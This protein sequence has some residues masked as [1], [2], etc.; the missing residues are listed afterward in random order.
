[1]S[2]SLDSRA[3]RR[4]DWLH[5]AVGLLGVAAF[6]LVLR[7]VQ[8]AN[9]TTVSLGLL[10][11]VLIV[12]SWSRLWVAVVTAVA[13]MLAFN[14]FFLPPVGTLTISDPHNWVALLAFLVAAVIASQLS[15]A[16][17]A[18]A[19]DA[20]DRRNELARLFD[21]S[22]D[23]LLT[24]DGASTLDALARHI[25]RRFDLERV[26]LCLPASPGW[27]IHQGGERDD[28]VVDEEELGVA[29][30][31]AG[32]TIEFDARQRT[33]GG[34]ARAQ[35]TSGREVTLVPVRFGTRAIGLLAAPAGAFDPGALDAVAGFAAIA[36]ERAQLLN[37]RKEAELT[38]QR[39]DLASTLLAS[40]SH[41]LR[42]P[43]TAIKVAMSNLQD[44][45]L[46]PEQRHT[47]ARLAQVELDRLT[48]LVQDILDMARI[49]AQAIELQHDWV[50]ASDIID[51]ATANLRPALEGR[52]LQIDADA[53]TVA[54]VEP[55]LTSAALSHL[56]ENALQYGPAESPVAVRGWADAEGLHL[57]VTDRGPG[58]DPR[59]LDHLFERFYRGQQARARSFGTGMG[60]AITRGLL[61]AEG[62]R[63]WGEN[64]DGGARFSIVV[65]SASQ[66]ARV[67]ATLD[68]PALEEPS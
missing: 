61:A 51:A 45:A 35:D 11:L 18:R 32:A 3:R 53:T 10:V 30:A 14:F 33:Y 60:L 23:V 19:R 39:A 6:V 1:M 58:L 36:V 67:A 26:A 48:R 38:R 56:I 66:P 27:Q 59:E 4:R 8:V 2:A 65:P 24:S 55:R 12:A 34:H 5:L 43:L 25:A 40:L 20:V 50:S 68:E 22:R 52:D 54:R 13:A 21:L 9:P 28:V 44:P 16:A 64:V 63:V 17:Q 46:P 49:D 62:G 47:Q 29:L 37:E 41:D 15:S 42:T 31:R 57:T 7:G